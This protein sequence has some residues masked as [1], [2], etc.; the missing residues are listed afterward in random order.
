[1]GKRAYAQEIDINWKTFIGMPVFSTFIPSIHISDTPLTPHINSQLICGWD[2]GLYPS[3]VV[4]QLQVLNGHLRL[5][6]FMEI[7]GENISAEEFVPNTL[8]LINGQFHNMADNKLIHYCDPSS[9]NRKDTDYKT[10][11]DVAASHGASMQPGAMRFEERKEAVEHWLLRVNPEGP[12]FIVDKTRC[13]MLVKGFEGGYRYPE[14]YESNEPSKI[15]PL[16]NE[17]SH[18]HDALQYACTGIGRMAHVKSQAP[19]IQR[20][21]YE[22]I[23]QRPGLKELTLSQGLPPI[24]QTVTVGESRYMSINQIHKNQRR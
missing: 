20:P 8:M 1:M 14:S 17:Y 16:K 15:R 19:K 10:W 4:T 2:Q 9:F 13:P 24:G 3:C 18:P 23:K 7:I 21:S 12:A 5:A 22:I 11:A 6:V